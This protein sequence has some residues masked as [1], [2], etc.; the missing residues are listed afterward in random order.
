MTGIF[1]ILFF[2]LLG[3][4]LIKSFKLIKS[5]FTSVNSR[6]EGKKVYET[7]RHGSKIDRKDVIDA[8]FE[9][10]D[11]KDKSST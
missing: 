4:I 3:Y 1:R 11:V 8:Q 10:I 2:I 6:D 5:I 9:E 7:K